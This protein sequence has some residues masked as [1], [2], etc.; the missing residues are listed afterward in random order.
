MNRNQKKM[1]EESISEI[2]K[3]LLVGVAI[4]TSV[5]WIPFLIMG[6]ILCFP[7]ICLVAIFFGLEDKEDKESDDY[8]EYGKIKLDD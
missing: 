8:V 6:I 5:F 2:L 7:F 3:T 4:L 1:N